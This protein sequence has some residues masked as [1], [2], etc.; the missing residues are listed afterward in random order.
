MSICALI[1]TG[2]GLIILV[3]H[4]IQKI[5]KIFDPTTFP[6]AMSVS[7]FLTAMTE[8]ASSGREVPIATIESQIIRSEIPRAVAI[9]MALSTRSFPQ[10]NNAPH[11]HRVKSTDFRAG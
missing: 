6:I 8:V 2:T 1:D 10:K 4:R 7:H 11:H 5:L 9:S 3:T